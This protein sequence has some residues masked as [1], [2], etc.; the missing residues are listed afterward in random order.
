LQAK[1]AQVDQQLAAT[2]IYTP[3]KKNRLRELLEQQT[4][5]KRDLDKSETAWLHATEELEQL[6]RLN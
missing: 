5:L 6:T 3:E 2:D 4:A 1:L